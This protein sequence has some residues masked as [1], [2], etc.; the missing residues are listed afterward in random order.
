[1]QLVLA[2]VVP[3]ILLVGFTALLATGRL[4]IPRN[5]ACLLGCQGSIWMAGILA[6]AAAAMAA[7]Q[8]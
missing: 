2:L 3:V 5:A 7:L 1:M 4:S 6:L 8:R